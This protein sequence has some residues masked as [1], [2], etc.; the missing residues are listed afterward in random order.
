[1]LGCGT[2]TSRGHGSK[3][4]VEKGPGVTSYT[5]VLDRVLDKGIVF[6]AWIRMSMAGIDLITVDAHVIVASIDTYLSSVA[7]SRVLF[8]VAADPPALFETMR[9]Q[10]SVTGI[11]VVLDRRRC[12]RRQRA[13]SAVRERRQAERRIRD[14]DRDLKSFGI[15]VVLRP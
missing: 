8:I 14:I 9:G 5:D 12:Q 7:M 13:E 1:M 4:A 11:N 6:D 3:M 10:N 15:A 2:S